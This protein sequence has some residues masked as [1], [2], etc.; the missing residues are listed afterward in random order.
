MSGLDKFVILSAMN[1]YEHN[2]LEE[3]DNVTY[4]IRFYLLDSKFQRQISQER[5]NNDIKNINQINDNSKIVIVETGV[6]DKYDITSL[7]MDTV[8]TSVANNSSATTYTIK[9]IVKEMNGCSLINKIAVVSKFLGYRTH[10]NQPYH[11]DIWFSGYE[12]T[13]GKPV[14]QIGE[15]LTYEVIIS[16]V[17]TNIVDNVTTYN[18]IMT[19]MASV[20]VNK[21]INSLW[22]IRNL[23]IDKDKTLEGY[24]LA[25][26]EAINKEFFKRNEYLRKSYPGEKYFFIDNLV[27]EEKANN[28][29][30]FI[31]KKNN[32]T[33]KTDNNVINNMSLKSIEIE[34]I[35]PAITNETSA[36]YDNFGIRVEDTFDGFFQRLCFRTTKLNDYIARPVYRIVFIQDAQMEGQELITVHVDIH[37]RKNT[38]LEYYN[39]NISL[40]NKLEEIRQMQASEMERLVFSDSLKKKYQ[41]LMNGKDTSVLE[42]NSSI[43][44]LWYACL[45]S[46]AFEQTYDFADDKVQKNLLLGTYTHE[47]FMKYN[48][49]TTNHMS[50]EAQKKMKKDETIIQSLNL[51]SNNKLYLDDIYYCID[52]K[53]KMEALTQRE[54]GEKF[55]FLETPENKNITNLSTLEYQS[56]TGYNNIY[57]AGNL[58]EL[59][60]KILGDP[61][62]LK[63]FSDNILM[64]GRQASTLHNFAFSVKTPIGLDSNDNYNLEECYEFSTIYQLIKS[65]S[66]FEDGKFIQQLE[67][68]INPAFMYSGS[69][70]V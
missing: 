21:T 45:P 14:Q 4:N 23:V 54:V 10:L 18:F 39:A 59:K 13:T 66:I 53:F 26:E 65:T 40:N 27:N 29:N 33:I 46:I 7:I 8:H 35:P 37:F 68:V 22:N 3:Y 69:V 32:K 25:I 19:P 43:D 63:Q 16:E 56:I 20:A 2:I 55:Q 44:N 41:Y 17:K 1:Q 47:K 42:L 31:L 62:W 15:L 50:P 61:Y 24:R 67:G 34:S 70:K 5:Y 36:E 48:L 52:N 38:Y 6:T 58:V 49:F 51:T 60:F 11:I 9:M 12:H 64:D 57:R 30:D 28:L